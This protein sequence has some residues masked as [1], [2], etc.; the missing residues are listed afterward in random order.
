MSIETLIGN[1]PDTLS[2]VDKELVQR[3]YR[4]AEKAHHGQMRASGEPYITHCVSVAEI[5]AAE[6]YAPPPII[7]AGLLHDTVEDTDITL[8]D[9]ERDF[10]P[11][12]RNLVDAVTKLTSL[13]R[14]SRGDQHETD[15]EEEEA[16]RT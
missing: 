14:V 2:M 1:L 15:E 16:E 6:M 5:L 8:S 13:P 11:D 3:A 12:I 4:V 7:A 9:L 10:G